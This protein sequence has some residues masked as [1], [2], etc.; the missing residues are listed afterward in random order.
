MAGREPVLDYAHLKSP[1]RRAGGVPA[2]CAL[3]FPAVP[4]VGCVFQ[5]GILFI[6]DGMGTFFGLVYAVVGLVLNLRG[7]WAA[8]WA[9]SVAV[10]LVGAWYFYW[11]IYVRGLC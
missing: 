4:L 2:A 5:I 9:V 8:L 11:L 10:N 7:P 1:G 3:L 6:I